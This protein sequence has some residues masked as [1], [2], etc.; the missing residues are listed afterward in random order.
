MPR[1]KKNA[2]I[3]RRRPLPCKLTGYVRVMLGRQKREHDNPRPGVVV[4]VG[5]WIPGE[6]V[7]K[8]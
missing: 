4:A 8:R 5:E 7:A 1:R 6:E 2:R 3:E